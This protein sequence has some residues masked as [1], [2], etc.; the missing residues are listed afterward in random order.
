M[1][2]ACLSSIA[3]ACQ[4]TTARH[5]SLNLPFNSFQ[6]AYHLHMEGEK[7]RTKPTCWQKILAFGPEMGPWKFS[8]VLGKLWVVFLVF[9]SNE[10]SVLADLPPHCL[11][12]HV[13]G[14]WEIHEG[15][16]MPCTHLEGDTKNIH[17]PYC[18]HTTP[19]RLGSHGMRSHC[20]N[21]QV[22]APLWLYTL[23]VSYC[24]RVYIE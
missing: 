10:V 18:G 21:A 24:G 6:Y 20:I 16:W 12:R 5:K 22:V 13:V 23:L 11:A 2:V 8:G 7:V 15:L 4:K 3:S 17:D 9:C 14:E 19:D 1:A